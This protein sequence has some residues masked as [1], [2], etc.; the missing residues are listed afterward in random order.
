MK[1]GDKITRMLAG[2]IPHELTITDIKDGLIHTG[3]GWT[4]DLE[5]GIEVDEELGWGPKYGKSGSFLQGFGV[6][7]VK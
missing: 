4:F 6:T 2:E 3:G 1:I 7:A 5:T